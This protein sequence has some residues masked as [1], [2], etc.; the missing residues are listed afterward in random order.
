MA[1]SF[2]Q[3]AER[4]RVCSRF[5][6]RQDVFVADVVPKALKRRTNRGGMVSKIVVTLQPIFLWKKLHTPFNAFKSTQ[7]F[8]G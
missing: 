2:T 8:D 3:R 5:D 7:G 6:D 4:H 1:E